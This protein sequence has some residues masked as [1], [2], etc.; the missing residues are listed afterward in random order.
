MILS[1]SNRL[2]LFY[3]PSGCGK[4]TAAAAVAAQYYKATQKPWRVLI[5]DGSLATY[6]DSGL[7]DMG[8]V[9]I[10]E[11]SFRPW[12][13]TVIQRLLEGWWLKDPSDPQSELVEPPKTQD[14]FSNLGGY[15]I[16]GGAMIS[17]Y[18]MGDVQGGLRYQSARGVKI[19]QDAPMKLVDTEYTEQGLPIKGKGPGTAFGGNPIS[20]FNYVQQRM[21][22][23]IEASKAL[24]GMKIWTTHEAAAE[25]KISGD[26][27]IGPE[28]AGQA[29]TKHVS[30]QFNNTFHFHTAA[31]K[32]KEKDDH[33][34]KDVNVLDSEYRIYTRDHYHADGA[35]M[36]RYRA[37]TRWPLGVD[38]AKLE[39]YYTSPIPGQAI[40]D[41]YNTI[42]SAKLE[43]MEKLKP[44][45]TA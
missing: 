5:G 16:E 6:E 23:F 32:A 17:Q 4:S 39:L 42:A 19:G 12:P 27:I 15:I 30:R 44:L 29:M 31:A 36:T 37:V 10:C 28:I 1:N 13:Q 41:I 26:K 22:N 2:E 33:T 18:L 43:A 14:W 20:H 25:D 34:G 40:I 8:V 21:F 35:M 38:P 45:A 9:Q 7:V 3:G 11:Y 24:P